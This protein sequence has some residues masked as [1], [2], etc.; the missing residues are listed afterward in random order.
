MTI[1]RAT[2]TQCACEHPHPHIHTRPHTHET[3]E[4]GCKWSSLLMKQVTE[5]YAFMYTWFQRLNQKTVDMMHTL[6]TNE[7]DQQSP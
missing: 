1:F 4:G 6:T 5:H 2:E 7:F 3:P